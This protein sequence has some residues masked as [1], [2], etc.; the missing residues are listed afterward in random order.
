MYC[1]KNRYSCNFC[2]FFVNY[3][4]L[5]EK[6]CNYMQLHAII[7]ISCNAVSFRL[8]TFL[9][10]LL[11]LYTALP[12]Y[13]EACSRNIPV[14]R[15]ARSVKVTGLILNVSFL[16]Q[17]TGLQAMTVLLTAVTI[18]STQRG[19]LTFAMIALVK[20]KCHGYVGFLNGYAK[21]D[22]QHKFQS[23]HE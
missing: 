18:V 4:Q 2:H 22:F 21:D 11:T 10:A 7:C 15:F 14:D 5:Y 17:N 9:Q 23:E 12:K 6:I 20:D 13:D 16:H 19:V 3:M 8:R 1:M